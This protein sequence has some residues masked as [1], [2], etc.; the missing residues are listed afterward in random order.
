[1][2]MNAIMER[3]T[4]LTILK[5]LKAQP[6]KAISSEAMRQFLLNFLLIDKPRQWVEVQFQYLADMSAVTIVEAGTV[7]IARLSERGRLHLEGKI[8][9]DGVLSPSARGGD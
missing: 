8:E 3:E 1:M 4:R 6:N 7:K 2:S 9:I 5:E